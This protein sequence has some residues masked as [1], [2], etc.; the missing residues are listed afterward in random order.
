MHKSSRLGSSGSHG[1]HLQSRVRQVDL[2][3]QA[4]DSPHTKAFLLLQ[5]G[6]DDG[7]VWLKKGFKGFYI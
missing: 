7:V 1:V 3:I 5:A 6:A 2:A 4:Y